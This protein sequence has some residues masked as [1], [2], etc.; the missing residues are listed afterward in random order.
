M[1]DC[2]D[3]KQNNNNNS[4]VDNAQYELKVFVHVVH[5]NVKEVLHIM[6]LLV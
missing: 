4:N 5:D 2:L 1:Y 6:Y 3:S